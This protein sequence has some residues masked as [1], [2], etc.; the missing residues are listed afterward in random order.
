MAADYT[1]LITPRHQTAPRFTATVALL[2]SAVGSVADV[3]LTLPSRF[4]LDIAEGAQLD[5]VGKWVGVGREIV[6]PVANQFFSWDTAGKG[7]GQGYW[8]DAFAPVDGISI[9]DDRSYRAALRLKI[10]RNRWAG[11]YQGFTPLFVRL[12]G[13][14]ENVILLRDNLNMSV[15]VIVY[16]PILSTFLRLLIEQADLIPRPMGVRIA[17]YTYLLTGSG[18][19]TGAITAP[20]PVFGLDESTQRIDGLDF[21]YLL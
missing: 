2:T 13:D 7:Y 18:G 1:D 15:D 12:E 3:T 16:G 10:L 4:D 21:G 6:S 11:A 8:K 17:S 19:G 9:L 14:V 20:V 5:A